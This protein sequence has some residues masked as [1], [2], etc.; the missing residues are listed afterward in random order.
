MALVVS[1]LLLPVLLALCGFAPGFYLLR[2]LRWRP[3]EKLCGSVG[4]SLALIY[5]ASWIIFCLGPSDGRIHPLPYAAVT[6]ACA[7]LAVAARKDAARL[8]HAPAVRRAVYGYAFLFAWTLAMLAGIRTYSGASWTS[9]WLEHFQRSLYFLY[10]F[11]ASTGIMGH[12]AL[13]A[14]PPMMNV[15]AAFFLAQTGDRF[16]NLQVIFAFLNLLPF[17]ACCQLL[18]R[19]AGRRRARVL[20]LVVLFALNPVVMEAATYTW[21]KAF[22]AFY[23]LLAVH[24]YLAAWRRQDSP[25]MAAAFLALAAATLVHYS[26]GPYVV[27]FTLH[28]LLVVFRRRPAKWREVAAIAAL[29][30]LFLATWF[31]WSIHTFGAHQT[32][33]SHTS[34]T[35]SQQYAG[36]NLEK[37]AGNLADTIVPAALRDPGLLDAFQQPNRLGKLRDDFFISYQTNLLLMI[38][39]AGGLVAA[40]MYWRALRTPRTPAPIRWFWAVMIPFCFVLG[41]AS[42][43][44]RDYFGLAHLTLLP[45]A[46]LGLTLVAGAMLSRRLLAAVVLCGCALDF[47]SGVWLQVQIEGMENTPSQTL[48]RGVEFRGAGAS[49]GAPGPDSLSQSAWTNWFQKHEYQMAGQWLA[50]M[51]ERGSRDAGFAARARSVTATLAAWKDEDRLLW[52][53]WFSRHGGGVTYLGDHF[54]ESGGAAVEWLL[55]AG[56][57]GMMAAMIRELQRQGPRAAPARGPALP[58]AVPA[59]RERVPARNPGKRPVAG[60][61]TR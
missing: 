57:L 47:A 52:H 50:A 40:W 7:I 32:F 46:F 49:V 56:M 1:I 60:G 12:Y 61:R 45:I 16:E 42:T 13:P 39:L 58:P 22:A 59:P 30:G 28:Y 44:E 27:F 3:M 10:R 34:V 37:I 18:P 51:L 2:R 41:V 36:H 5:L 24:F 17:L 15:V 26:A 55:V 48:F 8:W 35:T 19:L 31:G 29:C 6:L 21:T 11:P 53:G 14:R 20:P 25:R 38:G 9:D 43:G 54:G 4:L 33:A 23:I